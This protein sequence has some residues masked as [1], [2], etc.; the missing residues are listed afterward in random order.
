MPKQLSDFVQEALSSIEECS[1]H[2]ADELRKNG[3]TVLDVREG[4]EFQSGHIPGAYHVPR[5]FLEVR[6]DLSH[7]KRD[8]NM[9]DRSKKY[10]CICGGGHRSAL[11]AQT[12]VAMGFENVKS[13]AGGMSAWE[14]AKLEITT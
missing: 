10:L 3:W 12:L 5:G 13:V 2:A 4:D 6:A 8:A 7:P 11:A 14:A 9:A 1:V